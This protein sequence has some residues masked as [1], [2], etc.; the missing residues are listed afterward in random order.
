MRSLLVFCLAMLVLAGCAPNARKRGPQNWDTYGVRG[1]R[2]F[3][4][5]DFLKALNLYRT[6]YVAARR[7]DEIHK[8]SQYLFNTARVFFELGQ[9]DSA[10]NWFGK[11]HEEMLYYKDSVSAARAAVFLSL[12]FAKSA[13]AGEANTWLAKAETLRGK[14]CVHFYNAAACKV[15]FILNGTLENPEKLDAAASYYTK[16]KDYASLSQIHLLKAQV[17]KEGK[18]LSAARYYLEA[19]I[20]D[21]DNSPEMFRRYTVL[22]LLSE[23][24]FCSGNSDEGNRFYGRAVDCAPR[25][26]VLPSLDL[27]SRCD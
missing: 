3:L 16:K 24:S 2:C 21:L 7:S 10:A 22:L 5:G 4:E 13:R 8:T 19:A 26:V 27:I 12:C 15:G 6:G 1:Y 11:A 23:N 9:L 18:D 25:G 17:S 20:S 14:D